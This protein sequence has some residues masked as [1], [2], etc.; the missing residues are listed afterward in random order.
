MSDPF[1]RLRDR[2]GGSTAPDVA[3]IKARAR[4]IERRRYAGLASGAV[5]IALLAVV[6][7]VVGTGPGGDPPARRLAQSL[8]SEPTAAPATASPSAVTEPSAQQR[9][10]AAASAFRAQSAPGSAPSGESSG[11]G[12]APATASRAESDQPA[13]SGFEVTLD[14]IEESARPGRGVG[15]SL[16]ACN[17]SNEPVD[18]TFQSGQRYDFEVSRGGELVWRWSDGQAFTQ[19]YGQERWGP[20]ECKTYTEWWDG[21][22]SQGKVAPPGRYEAVGILTSSPP[23]RTRAQ[24]FCLDAC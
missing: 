20:G 1:E 12:A 4:R 19:V 10:D 11:A 8:E 13:R 21:T 14:V 18:L 16:K 3:A 7:I 5:A 22:D 17:R 9:R 6:G 23:Y 2:D 15:F 24:S